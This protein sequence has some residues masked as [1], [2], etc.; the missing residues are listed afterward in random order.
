MNAYTLRDIYVGLKEEFSVTLTEE[1]L[2]LFLSLSKDNNP[3]HV[4]AQ[5]AK[6]RGF[7]DRVVYGMLTSSFYSQLVGGYLPGKYALL[8]GIEISFHNPAY[9]GDE[10]TV[11]GEVSYI[12]EAYRQIE[13]IGSIR[14]SDN[15]LLSK[16]RIKV[17][18]NA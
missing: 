5:Y 3:L 16:A 18:V 14:N 1:M 2:G 4:N 9:V 12:N 17:G 6:E 8:Q 13:I 10:V 11:S 7:K 15:K